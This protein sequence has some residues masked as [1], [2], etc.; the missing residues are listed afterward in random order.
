MMQLNSD[1][2]PNGGMGRGQIWLHGKKVHDVGPNE[3][4]FISFV[5]WILRLADLI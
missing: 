1:F 4:E 3:L 5:K 2:F